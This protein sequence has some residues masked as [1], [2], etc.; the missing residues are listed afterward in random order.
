[1]RSIVLSLIMG[2][3]FVLAE[4][5]TVYA[6]SMYYNPNTLSIEQ[7]DSVEFINEG[8]FHDVE[9]VSGPESFSLSPCSG[10]CTI[11]TL[12]FNNPGTYDY[13]CSISNHEQMGMTGT[14][15]VNA[16]T[17]ASVQVI[18]NSASPTVDVYIDGALAVENFEY[19]TSTPVLELPTSFTVGIAPVDGDVIAEFPFDLMDGGEYVVVATGLLGD[20]TTPFDLAAAGTTFGASEGFVGLNVYH[21]STDAPSVDVL[22]DGAVLVSDL[23]YG[24]FSGYVEVP[25]ADYTIGVAPTGGE[26]I[27]DFTAPLAGLGGNSAVVFASGFLSGDDP[28]FGL[29]AALEDGVVVELP[30]YVE[31]TTASVQV[32][33]N[34]AS[35]T[36][37]VY[38]DGALAVENFEYRTSTPVLELPTSFTVGIAPV[39]GDVIAEF[40]FD[41]M[42]GGEYVVV[43]TG[44][45]GDATT[46]FDL[47]A[48]GTTFGA[49]EGFVGLNVY[50]GSTDAPSV[51]VLADGAVLVSDLM[52][53]S[54]SG[55]VE[56]PEADYTIGVAPTGGESIADFTAPLAG[57]GGNS[58]VVFASGFLSGDDPAFGL[59]AALEDGVVIELPSYSN[60]SNSNILNKSFEITSLYPNPF[61]PT[62]T[63][64]FQVPELTNINVDIYNINGQFVESLYSGFKNPGQHSINWN[65]SNVSTGVYLIRMSSGSYVETSK[66]MLLK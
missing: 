47:A 21:G 38:I 65:A 20:A 8:G 29:F 9:V 17:T 30:A 7:G 59:F 43:A 5:Y 15:T 18:H 34:S 3:S 19:R 41:L 25:E 33:H 26:S 16:Q 32:I 42:D 39:D 57:L 64:T 14:I 2:F 48:A 51:D 24:S 62:T 58:A 63:L 35:P 66:V 40:P 28:A 49:S 61:N 46:P 4:T 36:V 37:D 27:A 60:L 12:T 22:A 6:G 13:I 54:F 11:G 10:P 55:Y 56:V 53:G 44:L 31:P 23:M 52:Y 50:H 45:L 1:M